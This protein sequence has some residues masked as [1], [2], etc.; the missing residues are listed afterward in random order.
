M[1][2]TKPESELFLP[3]RHAASRLGV[4]GAWLLSEA[5]AGR[6]PSLRA[7][8]RWLVNPAAVERVLLDRA[9]RSAE[10]TVDRE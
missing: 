9:Q 8:R 6:V 4:P 10:G 3:I 1:S 2:D 5:K 7:G